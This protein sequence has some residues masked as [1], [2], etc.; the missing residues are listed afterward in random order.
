[1]APLRGQA[2]HSNRFIR[3]DPVC[4]QSLRILLSRIKFELN[5]LSPKNHLPRHV[6]LQLSHHFFTFYPL[7]EIHGQ[8]PV[9]QQTVLSLLLSEVPSCLLLLLFVTFHVWQ[10]FSG[11]FFFLSVSEISQEQPVHCNIVI[12]SVSNWLSQL[13]RVISLEEAGKENKLH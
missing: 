9:V 10:P 1:M 4:S 11:Q 6:R 13:R 8:K 12:A 5:P 3:N 7:T 2:R